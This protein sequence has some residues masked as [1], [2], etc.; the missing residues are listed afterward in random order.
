MVKIEYNMEEEM[1]NEEKKV[2]KILKKYESIEELKNILKKTLDLYH[3]KKFITY[4]KSVNLINEEIIKNYGEIFDLKSLE[5][6]FPIVQKSMILK[7][8]K[9]KI[10]YIPKLWSD[11]ILFEHFQVFY[12]FCFYLV[13]MEKDLNNIHKVFLFVEKVMK[14]SYDFDKNI[15]FNSVTKEYFILLKNIKLDKNASKLFDKIYDILGDMLSYII[16]KPLD[17]LFISNLS[18]NRFI[19]TF[20]AACNAVN[21]NRD[22]IIIEDVIIAYKTFYKLFEVDILPLLK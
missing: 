18:T 5:K 21:N 2:I 16:A 17:K 13:H 7:K 10:I 22:K 9:F 12:T 1:K 20:L 15:E 8:S 11:V 6:N 14:T 4:T 19:L 3:S